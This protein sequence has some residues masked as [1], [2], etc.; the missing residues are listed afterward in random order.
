MRKPLSQNG[1]PLNIEKTE[2]LVQPP[3]THWNENAAR[4]YID[5]SA[6]FRHHRHV[7]ADGETVRGSMTWKNVSGREYLVRL[8]PGGGQ[9]GLGVRSDDTQAAYEAFMAR[10]T[11]HKERLATITQQLELM[12]RLNKAVRVGRAPPVLIDTLGALEE[13]GLHHS[14]LTIG[15]AALIGFETA[16][17]VLAPKE[18]LRDAQ[19]RLHLLDLR[20]T[21]NKAPLAALQKAD[22]TFR[23]S[24]GQQHCA[25]N[26]SGYEVRFVRDADYADAVANR[27]FSQVVVGKTGRMAV[28]RTPHPLDF[29]ALRDRIAA[30]EDQAEAHFTTNLQAQLVQQLWDET[31]QYQLAKISPRPPEAIH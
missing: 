14:L 22:R 13:S 8:T 26:S 30:A 10:K 7:Q 28:M 19:M 18:L 23:L 1:F 15:S 16:A 6:V 20:N 21:S 3:Y 27:S 2:I 12:Q 17:A 31:M 5:A 29:V 11:R 9:H 24:K 25:V 4:Q